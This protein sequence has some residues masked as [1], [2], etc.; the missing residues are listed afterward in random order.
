MKPSFENIQQVR[1]GDSFVVYHYTAAYFPF[2]WHYH[3]EYELTL[4]LSGSGKRLVG[5]NYAGFIPGDLV[6]LGSNLPHTWASEPEPQPAAA[7][8]IQF[9]AAFITPFLQYP[10]CRGIAA[11]LRRS[12]KGLFFNKRTAAAVIKKIKTLLAAT[13]MARLLGLV[14]IL[15]HLGKIS[16]EPVSR[17]AMAQAPTDRAEERIN[18]ILQHVYRNYKKPFRV[19]Q[20]C[21]LIHL[22]PGAFCKFFKKTTGKTFSDYVNDVRVAKACNLLLETDRNIARIAYDVGFESITYFNRV[23]LKKKEITPGAFRHQLKAHL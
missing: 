5:D 2:K 12:E 4:I 16:A 11:L 7:V 14:D 1:E 19:D 20:L 9:S 10:E 22:S 17:L 13:G 23:F 21:R 8:V 6:L 18:K 15:H 3:P